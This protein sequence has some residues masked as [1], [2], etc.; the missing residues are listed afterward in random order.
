MSRVLEYD[1]LIASAL[2]IAGVTA[3]EVDLPA[4]RARVHAGVEAVLKGLADKLHSLNWQDAQIVLGRP[5]FSGAL[6]RDYLSTC[7]AGGVVAND[8]LA[9]LISDGIPTMLAERLREGDFRRLPDDPAQLARMIA[10]G[11][12]NPA[13]GDPSVFLPDPGLDDEDLAQL[14]YNLMKAC[15]LTILAFGQYPLEQLVG[16]LLQHAPAFGNTEVRPAGIGSI[17]GH[18]DKLWMGFEGPYG[19]LIA[20]FAVGGGD[21][22]QEEVLRPVS[23]MVPQVQWGLGILGAQ[24]PAPAAQILAGARPVR[25]WELQPF[26]DQRPAGSGVQLPPGLAAGLHARGWEAV[27]DNGFRLVVALRRGGTQA[28]IF[29]PFDAESFAVVAPL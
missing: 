23:S 12:V 15:G 20:F 27:S 28:V 26:A 22:V 1:E 8:K 25:L 19:S 29:T 16:L 7:E 21:F 2:Q 5:D 10:T 3:D 18:D 6:L 11:G 24:V 14:G 9:E 13:A 4:M 17:A